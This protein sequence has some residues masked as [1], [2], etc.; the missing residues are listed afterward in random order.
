MRWD[1]AEQFSIVQAVFFRRLKFLRDFL[2]G[3]SNFGARLPILG[4]EK[5]L[6]F[7]WFCW[8][9]HLVTQSLQRYCGAQDV[10]D[11]IWN[12]MRTIGTLTTWLLTVLSGSNKRVAAVTFVAAEYATV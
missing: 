12:F 8:M 3:Q 6:P 4:Q 5:F 10:E 7:A 2:C 1:T 9:V 11:K